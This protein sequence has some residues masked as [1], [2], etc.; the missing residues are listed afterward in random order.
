M[1]EYTQKSKGYKGSIRIRIIT[2]SRG[3]V[4]GVEHIGVAHA[5]EEKKIYMEL[6]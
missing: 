4:I 2:K 3:K 5:E 1:G 6:V